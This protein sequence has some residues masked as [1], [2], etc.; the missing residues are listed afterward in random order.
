MMQMEDHPVMTATTRDE[1][2]TRT[3][4]G[5][6]VVKIEGEMRTTDHATIHIRIDTHKEAS[7]DT[8][9]IKTINQERKDLV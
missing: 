8:T 9:R 7:E 6:A 2:K 4:G 5:E 1:M 3:L